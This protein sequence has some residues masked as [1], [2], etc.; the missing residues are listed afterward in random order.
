MSDAPRHLPPQQLSYER[1]PQIGNVLIDEDNANGS[2]SIRI[3]HPHE[4]YWRLAIL[5]FCSAIAL[6]VMGATF[7]GYV[8]WER[9]VLLTLSV[10]AWLFGAW[11]MLGARPAPSTIVADARQLA[12]HSTLNEFNAK[13]RREQVRDVRR[14]PIRPVAALGAEAQLVI[15]MTD[16]TVVELGI[17]ADEEVAA[18]V[19]A[20]RRGLRLSD[21]PEILP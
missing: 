20:I 14:L 11:A 6:T 18:M 12:F 13:W 17:G 19:E 7:K 16:K 15:E 3:V 8:P 10:A 5:T 9:A 21:T 2:V 4:R 1:S